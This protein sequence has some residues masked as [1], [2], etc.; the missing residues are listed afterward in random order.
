MSSRFTLRQ[1]EYFVAVGEVGSV[2]LAA[3]KVNVSAP[4]VSAAIAQLEKEFGLPLFVRK[5]AH[6][7]TLTLAGRQMVTQAKKTLSEAKTLNALANDILGQVKGPLSLG[8]LLTFAQFL[9]PNLRRRFEIAYPEVKMQQ[10]ELHQTEIFNCLRRAE[11]DIALTYDLELPPDLEFI[12]LL[13]LAPYAVMAEDHALA[14]HD[15]VSVDELKDHPMVLL[16][17]PH[18]SAYFLSFF[19]EIGATPA[20]AERTKDMAVMRSLVA[21]GFG[22]AIGN[23]RPVGDLSPDGLKL[24]YV[25]LTGAVR[26][27]QLGL[28]MAEGARNI[29]TIKAFIEHCRALIDDNSVPG[30]IGS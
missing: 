5:H 12:P 4:S 2:A 18:S 22:Y 28:L 17:L 15:A 9:V 3:E 21:N 7:L 16:D 27:M 29:L 13:S 26:P 23:I 20:I 19:R 25:P 1:L 8:C 11:I 10:F 24:R 14:H 6:G 30:L